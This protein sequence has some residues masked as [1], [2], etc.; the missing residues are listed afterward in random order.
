M[1]LPTVQQRSFHYVNINKPLCMLTM[2][3]TA[4]IPRCQLNSDLGFVPVDISGARDYKR[5]EMVH[6]CCAAAPLDPSVH[7]RSTEWSQIAAAV[8]Y[9]NRTQTLMPMWFVRLLT[10]DDGKRWCRWGFPSNR[11][12]T[13]VSSPYGYH[14]FNPPVVDIGDSFHCIEEDARRV[15]NECSTRRS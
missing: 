4:V 5:C 10:D 15:R 13:H 12:I 8:F 3:T 6:G 14:R 7:N 2:Q 9:D 11:R 1:K